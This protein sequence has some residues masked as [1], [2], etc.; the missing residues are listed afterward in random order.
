MICGKATE[1]SYK[2][3]VANYEIAPAIKRLV[4]LYNHIV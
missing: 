1:L 4:I 3:N 2:L